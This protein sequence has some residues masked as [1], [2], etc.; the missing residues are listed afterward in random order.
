MAIVIA[1]EGMHC[2]GCVS[3]VRNA[4]VRAGLPGVTVELGKAR[5]DVPGTDEGAIAKAREA[6]EKA[7]FEAKDVSPES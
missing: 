4:L 2:G 5:V 1:I 7:G 3:S 6:I